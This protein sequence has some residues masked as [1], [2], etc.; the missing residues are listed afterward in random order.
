M[1]RGPGHDARARMRTQRQLR[2]YQLLSPTDALQ[3]LAHLDGR[4][5]GN[6]RIWHGHYALAPLLKAHR[7]CDSFNLKPP[8]SRANFKC[9]PRL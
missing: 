1:R 4:Q 7:G 8:V 3:R 2:S 9:L 5:F 6:L